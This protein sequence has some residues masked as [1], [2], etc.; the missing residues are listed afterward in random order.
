VWEDENGRTWVSTNSLEYLQT[1]HGMA[2][3]PFVSVPALL[4]RALEPSE[5]EI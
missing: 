5:L 4:E 1:R 2:D 3:V